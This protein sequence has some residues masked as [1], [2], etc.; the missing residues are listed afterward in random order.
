MPL[1]PAVLERDAAAKDGL[2]RSHRFLGANTALP[3][4]RGDAEQEAA[5][6][7][8]C[9][10]GHVALVWSGARRVDACCARGG[11]GTAS[12]AGPWTRTRSGWR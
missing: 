12:P 11:S 8:S 9:A 5:P 3:H 1:E 2:I 7:P 4:L 10:A 6:P